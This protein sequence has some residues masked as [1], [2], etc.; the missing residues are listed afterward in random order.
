[1]IDLDDLNL[2]AEY[3]KYNQLGIM[4]EWASLVKEAREIGKKFDIPQSFQWKDKIIN[5]VK[6]V[7]IT[8]CGMGGSAIA[9]DYLVKLFEKDLNIPVIVNRDYY[10]P[11][12]VNENSLVICISYSGNTEETLSRY[13]EALQRGSMIISI[14]S[15]GYLEEFSKSIGV[16][17]LKIQ[18][19]LPPRSSLP[20]I[21]IS[22]ITLLEKLDI[23]P[24]ITKD[25]IE[26]EQLLK[27][28]AEEYSPD[29]STE[30]N[31]PKKIAYGLYN[32]LPVFLGNTIYSPV[33]YRAK[34]EFNENSKIIA[35][36]EEIP[37]HNH[38][39]IVVF[40]HPSKALNDVAF[41]LFRD[42]EETKAIKIRIEEIKKLATER[43]EKIL[44]INSLGKSVLAKQLSST[45]LIDYVS[46]YLAIL[47]E[48]DPTITPSID[49][50]K[51]V[52]KKNLNMLDEV[53]K[54][55]LK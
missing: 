1:M 52:L 16:P 29:V 38:N 39:G 8:V 14:S 44:E 46:I 6:P 53:R 22:L 19:G 15:A 48:V 5:F 31:I 26:T 23:V 49:K 41:V 54:Q 24:N 47:Y 36:N 21:Y 28:L 11:S 10:L 13:L 55:I 32:T 2:I 50:L 25:I 17:H 34:C 42:K 35:V 18:E 40:D 9:G 4:K 30:E 51:E 43:T 45:Y 3:D 7:N 12:F 27:K 20:L 33:A 37:E